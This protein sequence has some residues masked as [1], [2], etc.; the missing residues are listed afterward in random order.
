MRQVTRRRAL[1]IAL[2]TIATLAI[3]Q[4]ALADDPQATIEALERDL[5]Q[6]DATIAA[7]QTQVAELKPTSTP[8]PIPSPTPDPNTITRF[9]QEGTLLGKWKVMFD[10]N[11][12]V[13]AYVGDG[14]IIPR[15]GQFLVM[16]FDQ[17]ADPAEPIPFGDFRLEVLEPDSDQVVTAYE[18]AKEATSVL[19]LTEWDWNPSL[20]QSDFK[21]RTGMVFDIKPE[22][23]HFRLKYKPF[24][25][26]LVDIEF[27]A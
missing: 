15:R 2:G 6:R 16:W 14:S 24:D 27:A 23:V 19:I 18:V 8:T 10:P 7:L 3:A 25:E 13:R 17:M 20:M 9:E 21:Y 5:D 4:F 1:S 26:T 12:E 11:V 22:D